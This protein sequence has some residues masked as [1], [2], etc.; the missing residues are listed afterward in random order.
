MNQKGKRMNKIYALAAAALVSGCWGDRDKSA[1]IDH[2][3][4]MGAGSKGFCACQYDFAQ[5][6]LDEEIWAIVMAGAKGEHEEAERLK[7]EAGAGGLLGTAGLA[8][9][10]MDFESKTRQQCGG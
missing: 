7:K 5:T 8:I 6:E 3:V 9:V 10:L 2:C 4:G 1:F